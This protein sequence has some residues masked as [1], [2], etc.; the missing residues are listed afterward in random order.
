M[1]D[2]NNIFRLINSNEPIVDDAPLINTYEITDVDDVTHVAEGFLL[3]TS[4]HVAVMQETSKG[5]LPLLV[6]PLNRVKF[7]EMV[8]DDMLLDHD[9]IEIH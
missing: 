6:I 8:D 1:S 7:A 5:A 9:E 2:D 3:F 4:Q